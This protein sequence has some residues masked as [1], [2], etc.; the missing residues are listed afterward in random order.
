MGTGAAASQVG[1]LFPEIF[2]KLLGIKSLHNLLFYKFK[3]KMVLGRQGG[4]VGG[5]TAAAVM[6]N[7]VQPF[8]L[9]FLFLIMS[10]KVPGIMHMR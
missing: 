10:K 4:G 1:W 2:V 8:F 6:A 3:C 9:L 7:T 5:K